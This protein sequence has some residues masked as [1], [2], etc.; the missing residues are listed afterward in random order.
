MLLPYEIIIEISNYI[1]SLHNNKIYLS[2]TYFFELHKKKFLKNI[3]LIQNFYKKNKLPDDFLNVKIFINYDKYC[4]W[5]RITNRNNKIRIYRFIVK[6]NFNDN[7][8]ELIM[9]KSCTMHSSRQ[10]IL[11]DWIKNNIPTESRT[12]R[13]LM[14]FFIEN[15]I[16]LKEISNVGF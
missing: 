6:N 1:P 3:N 14:N 13:D 2:N 16:T 5:Q 7:Y 15:I 8:P 11:K 4:K 9:K 12:R 10:L